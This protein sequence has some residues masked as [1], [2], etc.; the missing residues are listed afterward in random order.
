MDEA[1]QKLLAAGT[2]KKLLYPER[3]GFH[4]P[5]PLPA[6]LTEARPVPPAI[7]KPTGTE[8]RQAAE[9]VVGLP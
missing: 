2:A 5:V 1:V 6:V 4:V 7:R 9:P 8:H 3:T